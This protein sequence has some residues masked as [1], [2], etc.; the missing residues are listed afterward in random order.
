MIKSKQL[1]K[2]A[3]M[4]FILEMLKKEGI[5]LTNT[6]LRRDYNESKRSYA[7]AVYENKY[8]IQQ[9]LGFSREELKANKIEVWEAVE[10][11]E[12]NLTDIILDK[13]YAE[14]DNLINK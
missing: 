2:K 1:I 9:R 10:H 6:Y 13:L 7:H 11:L 12:K 4:P 8:N 14:N 3:I 5:V